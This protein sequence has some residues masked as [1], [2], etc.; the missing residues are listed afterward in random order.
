MD[1]EYHLLIYHPESPFLLFYSIQQIHFQ[2]LFDKNRDLS[3]TTPLVYYSY[4]H[5]YR[6]LNHRCRGSQKAEVLGGYYQPLKYLTP[7]S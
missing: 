5:I 3:Q 6:L 2:V 1:R 7:S 4:H